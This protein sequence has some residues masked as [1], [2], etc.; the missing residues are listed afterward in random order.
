MKALV[1]APPVTTA[2][3]KREGRRSRTRWY[4]LL[5]IASL[6]AISGIALYIWAI[7]LPLSWA[8][9]Y[10]SVR[11]TRITNA[12]ARDPQHLGG[13]RL[14][15]VSRELGLEDVSWDD[16]NVQNLAGSLRIYHFR[17]FA[18]YVTL[19]YMGEGVTEDMLLERGSAE[20]KL[21]GRDLVRINR[22]S[23]PFILID[24]ISSREERMRRYWAREEEAMKDINEQ[25]RLKRQKM[26][27]QEN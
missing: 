13:R 3:S 14:Y 26:L 6:S 5:G 18:L 9:D 27:N 23:A 16:G 12:I 21:R 11:Y 24:G 1:K 25:M 2:G 19:D 17:G 7:G 15:D 22:S 10:D 4:V 8:F 20:E